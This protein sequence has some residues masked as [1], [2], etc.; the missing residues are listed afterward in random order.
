MPINVLEK[1]YSTKKF[2]YYVSSKTQHY[3]R[4]V[5]ERHRLDCLDNA[6]EQIFLSEE[7]SYSNTKRKMSENKEFVSYMRDKQAYV[8]AT[9]HNRRLFANCQ[10]TKH[11]LKD[12]FENYNNKFII[13]YLEISQGFF[14][15]EAASYFVEKIKENTTVAAAESVYNN[16]HERLIN[17]WLKSNFTRYHNKAKKG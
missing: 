15:E 8:G 6:Y 13:E 17:S 1:L 3:G 10:Q 2:T 9:E 4:F 16:N 5:F 12:L 7:G 14:D 11:A